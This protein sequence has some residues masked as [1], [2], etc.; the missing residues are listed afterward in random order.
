MSN[1]VEIRQIAEAHVEWL[2]AFVV[3]VIRRVGIEEFIHGYKHGVEDN[4]K[5]SVKESHGADANRS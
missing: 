4:E 2:I 1:D 3:P 5:K